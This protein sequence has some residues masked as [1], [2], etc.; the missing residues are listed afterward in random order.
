LNEL[1]QFLAGSSGLVAKL[2]ACI[3]GRED[4]TTTTIPKEEEEKKSI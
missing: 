1:R 4:I 2:V 3:G